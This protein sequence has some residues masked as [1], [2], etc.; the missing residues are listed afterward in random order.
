V[1]NQLELMVNQQLRHHLNNN[2]KLQNRS[3]KSRRRAKKQ[4]L[5]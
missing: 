1:N 5:D 2:R 4:Q 3:L